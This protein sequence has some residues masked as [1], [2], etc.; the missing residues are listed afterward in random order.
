MP[1]KVINNPA[2]TLSIDIES[3]PPDFDSRT[4]IN[5][6]TNRLC[7]YLKKWARL[8]LPARRWVPDQISTEVALRIERL[9]SVKQVRCPVDY[10]PQDSLGTTFPNC[11]GTMLWVIGADAGDFP[12]MYGSRFDNNWQAC[13]YEG[14]LDGDQEQMFE[15][16]VRLMEAVGYVHKRSRSINSK[17]LLENLVVGDVILFG[18]RSGRDNFVHT[19]IY[20]GEING[21][22]TVFEKKVPNVVLEINSDIIHYKKL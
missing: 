16:M 3:K 7:G 15:N 6:S 8:V 12:R 21:V 4:P 9:L 18:K 5:L 22:P 14:I 2:K 10:N 13:D 11:F 19:A 1:G 17:R 20:I